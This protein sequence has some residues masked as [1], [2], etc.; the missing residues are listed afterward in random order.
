MAGLDVSVKFD[1]GIE[2][3][4]YGSLT[5][6]GEEIT[7]SPA[8]VRLVTDTYF[9]PVFKD[10]YGV[11]TANGVDDM[12]DGLYVWGMTNSIEFTSKPGGGAKYEHN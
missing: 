7:S 9:R 4:M 11:D 3:V 8:I 10:G 5:S 12:G 1:S 6:Q 2:K